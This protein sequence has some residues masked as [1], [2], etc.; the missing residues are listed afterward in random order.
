MKILHYAVDAYSKPAG[1][2]HLLDEVNVRVPRRQL[3]PLPPQDHQALR[4]VLD[5]FSK[6]IESEVASCPMR[7]K[8]VF[9]TDFLLLLL[10]DIAHVLLAQVAHELNRWSNVTLAQALA[11]ALP[12]VLLDLGFHYLGI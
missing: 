4:H 2:L 8:L 5:P 7:A 10:E 1:D 9:C 11:K 12:G 6:L 3:L